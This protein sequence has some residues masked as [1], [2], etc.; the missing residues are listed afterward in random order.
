MRTEPSVEIKLLQVRDPRS[1][2]VNKSDE[3]TLVL[4]NRDEVSS[5]SLCHSVEDILL[6]QSQIPITWQLSLYRLKR[7]K[8]LPVKRY[9]ARHTIEQ[10]ISLGITK[11]PEKSFTLVPMHGKLAF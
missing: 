7:D 10:I 5:Y 4:Q 1:K 2:V 6:R 9:H 8:M 3:M 11:V